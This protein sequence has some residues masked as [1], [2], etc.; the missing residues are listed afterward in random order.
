MVI[1][2]SKDDYINI[3][4]TENYQ[5]ESGDNDPF[6]IQ[7]DSFEDDLL[8]RDTASSADDNIDV[9]IIGV[10]VVSDEENCIVNLC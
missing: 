9:Q 10:E 5:I 1:D 4:G 6:E 7:D 3:K 2:D 8:E